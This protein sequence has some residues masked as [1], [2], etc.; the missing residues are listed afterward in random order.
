LAYSYANEVGVVDTGAFDP[1]GQRQQLQAFTPFNTRADW[2]WVPTL[3]WSPDGR[4]LAF[5]RHEGE[6]EDEQVF[7]SWVTAVHGDLAASFVNQTG[8]WGHLYWSPDNRQIAFLK[9]TDPLDSLRSNYTLW[10]MDV[11]GSNGRQ[12]YPP[13]GENS[14]FSRDPSFMTWGP[15]GEQI[16]FIFGNDLFILN[17]AD[18]NVTR[19]T[20]DDTRVTHPTWAPYGTAVAPPP[21]DNSP[22]RRNNGG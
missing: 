2:V 1:N 3:T 14:Q 16:A 13:P 5:T 9:A 12:L 8:M 20:Q 11:D 21:E 7:D 18:E 6:D 15:S 19:I 22:S 17:L 10:L 4:F